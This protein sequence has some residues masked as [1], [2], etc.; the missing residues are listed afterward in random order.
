MSFVKIEGAPKAP[1]QEAEGEQEVVGGT[2][3]GVGSDDLERKPGFT[4][5]DYLKVEYLI[6]V[7]RYF[8]S[9]MQTK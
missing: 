8:N 2:S 3:I 1:P 9:T 5:T 6:D 4:V 7:A